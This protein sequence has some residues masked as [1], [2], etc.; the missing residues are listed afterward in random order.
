MELAETLQAPVQGGGRGMPNQHPLSGGGNVR[1][2]DV[3]LALNEEGLYGRLNRYRDQ[4]V[5]SSTPLVKSDAKVISIS[6]YD[7]YMHCQDPVCASACLV[8]AHTL[9]PDSACGR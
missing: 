8:G 4:Q 2:A 7:L 3:I 5:R 9:G 1:T 6:S